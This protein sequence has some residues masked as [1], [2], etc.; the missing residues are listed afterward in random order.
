M[1]YALI[2]LALAWAAPPT[3]AAESTPSNDP[4]LAKL[5][6]IEKEYA[7][8]NLDERMGIARSEMAARNQELRDAL[9]GEYAESLEV[10]GAAMDRAAVG[11][12]YNEFAQHPTAAYSLRKKYDPEG[13]IGFCFGR[14]LAIHLE[15]LR[16]G[17]QKESIRKIWVVGEL[18]LGSLQWHHHVAT[19]VRAQD[20][21]WWVI[22]P[23]Y[24]APIKATHWM[25]RMRWIFGKWPSLAELPKPEAPQLRFFV[26]KPERF[27]PAFGAKYSPKV[28][29]STNFGAFFKDLMKHNRERPRLSAKPRL[30]R[31]K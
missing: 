7:D 5:A 18:K 21:G 24:E 17:I 8:V 20:G 25:T 9:K 4:S 16:A 26:T 12:L 23:M 29:Q 13:R 15:L 19:M 10:P 22:D 28:I 30:T 3:F 27:G 11:S 31:V 1:T 14:A 6:E 2:A